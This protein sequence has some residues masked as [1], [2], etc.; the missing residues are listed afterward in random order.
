MPCPVI[1]SPAVPFA[2]AVCLPVVVR[3]EV[4]D[5]TIIQVKGR[6][7]SKVQRTAWLISVRLDQL[8]L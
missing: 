7:S 6:E 4:A 5:A 1:F 8:L 3:I 2:R